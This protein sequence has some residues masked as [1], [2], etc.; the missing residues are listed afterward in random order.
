LRV[1]DVETGQEI[2]ALTNSG[3]VGAIAF[4]PDGKSVAAGSKDGSVRIL[5]LPTAE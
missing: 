1:W 5:V 3:R 4:R 2:A